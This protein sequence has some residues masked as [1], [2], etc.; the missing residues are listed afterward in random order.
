ML[1]PADRLD[2]E[3]KILEQLK[4]GERVDH[5]ETI[6]VGKDGSQLNISLTISFVKDANG[7][8]IGASEVARDIID[9]MSG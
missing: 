3:S 7:R 1:I 6:R 8:I 2:E 5:F 4:R 9:R